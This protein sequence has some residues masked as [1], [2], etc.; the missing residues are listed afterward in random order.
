MSKKV[1]VGEHSKEMAEFVA[2]FLRK[3]G[4]KTEV[5]PLIY[6]S[7]QAISDMMGKEYFKG[8]NPTHAVV[9]SEKDERLANEIT[10]KLCEFNWYKKRPRGI[11][12]TKDVIPQLYGIKPF[13]K[14]KRL[15]K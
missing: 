2:Y 5:R 11:D 10:E 12:V 15:S 8:W 7:K 1:S 9:V 14:K 6:S 4:I 3:A 13:K